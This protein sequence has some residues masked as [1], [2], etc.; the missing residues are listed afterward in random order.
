MR[1]QEID[2]ILTAMLESYDNVSDLNF[3]VD[4]ACQVESSGQLV[5]VSLN[6]PISKITLFR[7]KSSLSTSLTETAGSPDF[8]CRKAPVTRPI[9]SRAK[10]DSG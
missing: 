2:H 7:P 9:S 5:P 6:P 1:R 8:Y 10:P 4:K 3:T